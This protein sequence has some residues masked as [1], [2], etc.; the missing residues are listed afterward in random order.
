M[1][2]N[3]ERAV[4]G[5]GGVTYEEESQISRK[6]IPNFEE[7]LKDIDGALHNN[8]MGSNSNISDLVI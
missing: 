4:S 1:E 8:Y 5:D 2:E 6:H 7:I 3:G